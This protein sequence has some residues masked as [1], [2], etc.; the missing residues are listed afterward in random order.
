MQ[1]PYEECC[2]PYSFNDE[3]EID[4]DDED[5]DGSGRKPSIPVQG[6]SLLEVAHSLTRLLKRRMTKP[7]DM[8]RLEAF[9]W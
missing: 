6:T 1:I 7:E 4:S 3:H 2:V 5:E 9:E 8:Y